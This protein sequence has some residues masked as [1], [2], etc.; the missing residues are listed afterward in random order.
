MVN[1]HKVAFRLGGA[2]HVV[3]VHIVAVRVRHL[4]GGTVIH[5]HRHPTGRHGKHRSLKEQCQRKNHI[6]CASINPQRTTP[7]VLPIVYKLC[8]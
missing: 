2:G 1:G 4:E 3:A 5:G 6:N 8:A 7:C